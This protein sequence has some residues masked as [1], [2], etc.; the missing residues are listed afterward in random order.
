[1]AS[2]TVTRSILQGNQRESG[3]ILLAL[4]SEIQLKE[5]GRPLIANDWKP[6]SKFHCQRLKKFKF[7]DDNGNWLCSAKVTIFYLLDA[8]SDVGSA[9]NISFE[10]IL[11]TLNFWNLSKPELYWNRRLVLREYT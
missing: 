1:M 4:E 8:V 11:M 2:K 6:E 7:E 10:E 5:S 3:K 9:S